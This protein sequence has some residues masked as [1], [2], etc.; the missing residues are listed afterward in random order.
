[1][2]GFRSNK[3]KTPKWNKTK[4]P[5]VR[6]REYKKPRGGT[7]KYFA[8]RYTIEGRQ[9]EEGLGWSYQGWN[10]K[11]ASFVLAEL[12]KA[13]VTGEG[14]RTLAERRQKIIE[15]AQQENVRKEKEKLKKLTFAEFFLKSY[16]PIAETNK[17]VDTIRKEKEHFKNWIMPVIGNLPLQSIT[18]LNV[19]RIK[20]NMLD[21]DRSP[22]TVQYVF[23]TVRQ[24]WNLAIRDGIVT[25]ESPT[26][27][28]KLIKFDNK[29][30]R[31]LTS[32]EADSLIDELQKCST[33]THKIALISLHCGA[34][35]DEIFKLKWKDV[36]LKEGSLTLWDTKNTKTRTVFMTREVKDIFSK[37]D[38]G[39][40]DELVFRN[41]NGG[42]INKISNA[43]NRAVRKL[44][45]N[46][47]VTDRRQKVVFHTLRHTYASWHVQSGTDL[48][49]LQKL[50]GLSSFALVERYAHLAPSTL[51]AA[52]R[53][54]EK[55]I[56]KDTSR[57]VPLENR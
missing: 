5:G 54:F 39:N 15:E 10:A 34:R 17:K 22:R 35:A 27:A 1:M 45:F 12:K 55:S 6:Y 57:L 50:M 44:G 23:A 3:K 40:N 24:C 46:D 14:Q 32:E 43:F 13:I 42:K 49:T 37:L 51:Q 8:I 38:R 21:K 11:K 19:E 30:L 47:G 56:Q 31:F 29:R 25:S 26:R 36:N 28:V 16:L 7:K 48:Y 41:R 18:P 2:P 33:N 52:T 53:N 20:K 4:Y 9:R